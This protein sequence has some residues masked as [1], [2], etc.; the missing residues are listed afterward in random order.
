MPV[1]ISKIPAFGFSALAD[2]CCFLD[3]K[4]VPDFD[5][6]NEKQIF[7]GSASGKFRS[8]EILQVSS[9][10]TTCKNNLQVKP[11][12]STRI[13]TVSYWYFRKKL[14]F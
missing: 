11:I 13:V 4:L 3:M 1:D 14:N 6:N 9:A 2:R 5:R 12:L 8:S 10:G 7:A